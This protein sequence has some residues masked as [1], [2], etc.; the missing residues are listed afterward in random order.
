MPPARPPPA[1]TAAGR[2]RSPPRPPPGDVDLLVGEQRVQLQVRRPARDSR[3]PSF[4]PPRRR[5]ACRRRGRRGRHVVE[6]PRTRVHTAGLDGVRR[7]WPRRRERGA[8]APG[9]EPAARRRKQQDASMAWRLTSRRWPSRA[10]TA[11]EK[12]TGGD[13]GRGHRR[14]LARRGELRNI[15]ADVH[16]VNEMFPGPRDAR[17]QAAG[18]RRDLVGE[19]AHAEKWTREG[20][21]EPEPFPSRQWISWGR[22]FLRAR[23]PR[24]VRCALHLVTPSR[25]VLRH[26]W[27]RGIVSATLPARKKK[28]EPICGAGR[29]HTKWSAMQDEDVDEAPLVQHHAAGDTNQDRSFF[30]FYSAREHQRGRAQGQPSPKVLDPRLGREPQVAGACGLGD[31]PTPDLS[32][33]E[34]ESRSASEKSK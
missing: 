17:R 11:R 15:N 14:V 28:I 7:G 9:R 24:D 29:K 10:K 33:S 2:D 20:G 34:S 30:F 23:A 6:R 3:W 31:H 16:K 12:H 5:Q 21:R 26:S 25:I 8:S 13:A 1:G 4:D 22:G 19:H 27:S 18:R 32:Q